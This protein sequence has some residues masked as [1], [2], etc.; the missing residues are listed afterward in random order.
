[1]KKTIEIKGLDDIKKT[2]K[3]MKAEVRKQIKQ[4]VAATALDIQAEAKLNLR[5]AKAINTGELGKKTLV[6]L[7][8]DGMRAEVGT[9]APH[10]KWVEFGTKHTTKMPPPDALEHW[11]RWHGMEGAEFAI[12][13]NILKRGGLSARP[14][15]FPAFE[16]HIGPF[17]ER[18]RKILGV[19]AQ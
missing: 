19:V 3:K 6:E 2:L 9:T 4:E 15:L 11:A 7:T 12:A 14:W 5:E 16:K 17:F 8:P 13:K 1:M 10:G 18:I